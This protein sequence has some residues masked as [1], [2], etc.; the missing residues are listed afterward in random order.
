MAA[1][2]PL[3]Q[4]DGEDEELSDEQKIAFAKWFLLNSPPGEIQYV[5]KDLQG[6]LMDEDIFRTAA[7][8]AFAQY[9]KEQM[10]SLEMPDRSGQVLVTQYGEIDADHYVDLRT[11]QVATVDHVK[12]VCTGVRPAVDDE[13]PCAYVEEYRAAIDVELVRYVEEAFPKGDC[14]VYATGGKD[15]NDVQTFE[16]TAV[17]SSAKFRPQNFC[18]GRWRSMWGIH[19]YADMQTV[20]LKGNMKVSAHYFEEGN[21]QLDSSYEC[22]DSTVFQ[23]PSETGLAIASIIQYHESEYL[24]SL[25]DSY[26]KLSDNTFKELRRKLPVTRTLFPWGNAHQL[27]LAREL[28]REMSIK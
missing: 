18:N 26:S 10:I 24:S 22:K 19:T 23:S 27:S 3:D 5:A 11:A 1:S 15:V 13:L 6:V 21:V 12:Q 2:S 25:E 20:E 9:N 7:N 16:L 14:A 8:D 4:P 17:I 28:S